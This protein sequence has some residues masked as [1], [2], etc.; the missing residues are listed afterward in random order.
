MFSLH[1]YS[2]SACKPIV[3][4]MH[5]NPILILN[6]NVFTY[7]YILAGPWCYT[8]DE[9]TRWELCDIPMCSSDKSTISP[10]TTQTSIN[11]P[12][13]PELLIPYDTAS[14]KYFKYENMTVYVIDEHFK[15]RSSAMSHCDDYYSGSLPDIHTQLVYDLVLA[16]LDAVGSDYT[17]GEYLVGAYTSHAVGTHLTSLDFITSE[18]QSNCPVT[19]DWQSSTH[20]YASKPCWQGRR[21]L[22]L[23]EVAQEYE[24]TSTA[25]P[26]SVLMPVD[27]FQI[28]DYPV[29]NG[30]AEK[31][32]DGNKDPNYNNNGCTHTH[33]ATNPWWCAQLDALYEISSV[34]IVNRGDAS[35]ERAYNVRVGVSNTAPIVGQI[36]DPDSYILCG[37]IPGEMGPTGLIQ[38][39]GNVIGQYVI[40]QTII[41][42]NYLHLCEVT[43]SGIFFKAVGQELSTQMTT[44]QTTKPSTNPENTISS[45]ASPFSVLMP[46][47]VFQISDW[48]DGNGG[49]EKAIDGN[50]DPDYFNNGCICTDQ[51]T[52]PWWCAKLDALYEISSLEIVNRGE[53]GERTYD[54]RVGVSNT[55]PIVGQ[56]LDPESYVLCGEIPGEMGPL[57]II[58]CPGNLIGQYVI[59]QTIISDD[60]LNL[61]EVTINGK[62]VHSVGQ[63]LSTQMTTDQPARPSTNSMNVEQITTDQTT[64]HRTNSVNESNSNDV[65]TSSLTGCPC[66][67]K[68]S[69][70]DCA[71]CSEG[72]CQCPR[73]N[74]HQC[75]QCGYADQCGIEN[76]PGP[77]NVDGWTSAVS[78]CPCVFNADQDCPCCQNYGCQCKNGAKKCVNCGHPEHCL[79]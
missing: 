55:A 30:G 42:N 12:F 40:V 21:F 78:G 2:H 29:G 51:A 3:H 76:T 28:S 64:K 54:V 67:F 18:E 58:G 43:I 13:D 46:V 49:A 41:S 23:T 26:F 70:F 4:I 11:S 71:C 77:G 79:V 65:W 27:A 73:S 8:Q 24:L 52:N 17:Y 15:S 34:A 38:C 47:D 25:S 10:Q 1:S 37:E 74:M 35:A 68:P 20:F 69:N 48:P 75:V 57:G 66:Y 72:G 61:C 22:C 36:L 7:V 50:K 59:V 62:F 31:A 45:T 5:K 14:P 39:A 33:Q 56:I 53:F 19:S 9:N 60:Y 63:E 32:I 16:G 44:D 6:C